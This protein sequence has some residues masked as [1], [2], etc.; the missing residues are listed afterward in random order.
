MNISSTLFYHTRLK[1]F[2]NLFKIHRLSF[3]HILRHILSSFPGRYRSQ[4]SV[5]SIAREKS[6]SITEMYTIGI[7]KGM[8]YK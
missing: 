5:F 2:I 3:R 7:E 1:S 8:L 6:I 4:K